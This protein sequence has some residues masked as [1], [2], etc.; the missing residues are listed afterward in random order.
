MKVDVNFLVVMD[1]WRKVASALFNEEYERSC[2]DIN[3][4][5]DLGHGAYCSV[6]LETIM[7]T[8]VKWGQSVP[9][10]RE[11]ESLTRTQQIEVILC[12]LDT[13]TVKYGHGFPKKPAR[14]VKVLRWLVP[15]P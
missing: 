5:Q 6:I 1:G 3:D 10:W 12:V 11:F 8:Y 2:P 13:W 4:L 15:R 14:M 7:R 9:E